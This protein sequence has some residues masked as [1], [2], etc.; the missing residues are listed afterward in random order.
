MALLSYSVL[1]AEDFNKPQET[2]TTF[3]MQTRIGETAINNI[4]MAYFGGNHEFHVENLGDISLKVN[5]IG[6]DIQGEN[7]IAFGYDLI[8]SVNIPSEKLS[9]SERS[10][11]GAFQVQGAI[12]VQ[13]IQNSY[14]AWMNFGEIV[15]FILTEN[16]ID[17]K[18]IAKT[19]ESFFSTQNG[20]VELWKQTYSS[21]LRNS[22]ISAASSFDS[23]LINR[24]M[25]YSIGKI[26]D[27]ISIDLE[28]E[29]KSKLQYFWTE[30]DAMQ[31]KFFLI[32]NKNFKV[33]S[34]SFYAM[35][36]FM[37]GY[38]NSCQEYPNMEL[39]KIDVYE[40]CENDIEKLKAALEFGSV[41][42]YIR[43]KTKHGGI[44]LLTREISKKYR[45]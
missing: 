18:F 28:V 15:N 44:L 41:T 38:R 43:V 45:R 42:V 39:Q 40:A 26:D 34:I 1:L 23:E 35:G 5:D 24:K 36:D 17:S 14:V 11:K 25:S 22:L 37:I 9:F 21:L 30:E 27:M 8:L 10:L 16:Q 31:E 19:L 7:Q 6:I 20:L 4:L 32:S 12:S 3:K 33:L 29:L 13:D 2:T